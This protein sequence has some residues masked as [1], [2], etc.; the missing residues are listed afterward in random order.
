VTWLKINGEAIYATRPWKIFGEGPAIT[1]VESA[2]YDKNG[3]KDVSN[4][5]FTVEDIR[6]T[7]SK[8]D[9]TLYAIV[10]EIPADGKVTVKSLATNSAN[11]PVKSA[12]FVWS[13]A[14]N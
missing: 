12:A 14:A 4:K 13:A 8:D 11:W 6:F 9:R 1:A 5:P 10:L 3:M 2:P 7:Q